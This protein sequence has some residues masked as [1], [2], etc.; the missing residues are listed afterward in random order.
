M[1]KE[2]GQM[3][4]PMLREMRTE[5]QEGFA[6][7]NQRLEKLEEGQK[8]FRNALSADSLMSKFVIGD[9]E[10]RL[11]TLERRFDDFTKAK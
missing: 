10:E 11:A 7:V 9:F 1:T 4:L 8:S 3:I 6:T 5:M 2:P